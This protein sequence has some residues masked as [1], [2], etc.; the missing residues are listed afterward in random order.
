VYAVTPIPE[1]AA[2]AMLAGG[3]GLL[4]LAALAARRRARR[5]EGGRGDCAPNDAVPA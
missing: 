5:R 1:P 3:L 4:P 2:A